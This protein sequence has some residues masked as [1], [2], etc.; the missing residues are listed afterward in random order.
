MDSKHLE[1]REPDTFLEEAA[2]F[3]VEVVGAA[4]PAV[5]APQ[6]SAL[7]PDQIAA[8]Q[9]EAQAPAEALALEK[10]SETANDDSPFGVDELEP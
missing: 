8:Y 9:A 7:T 3:N 4:P 1:P 10:Q 5:P 6:P 2:E